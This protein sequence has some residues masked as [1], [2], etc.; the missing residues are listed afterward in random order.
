MIPDTVAI[1]AWTVDTN[2]KPRERKWVTPNVT[3]AGPRSRSGPG[4]VAPAELLAPDAHSVHTLNA[5]SRR[6]AALSPARAAWDGT[7]W[8]C[9]ALSPGDTG[10]GDVSKVSSLPHPWISAN[11]ARVP[12][13]R[14]GAAPEH[15]RWP[16]GYRGFGRTGPPPDPAPRGGLG[17]ALLG[18]RAPRLQLPRRG[19]ELLARPDRSRSRPGGDGESPR[20]GSPP[21]DPARTC[22]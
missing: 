6:G 19:S 9:Q 8:L 20:C 18:V 13:G 15:P 1:V 17:S 3:P 12:A 16:G 7:G 21:A 5:S 14:G 4:A 2:L 11:S 10:E 22:R